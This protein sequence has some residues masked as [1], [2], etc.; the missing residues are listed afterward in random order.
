MP[1]FLVGD[2]LTDEMPKHLALLSRSHYV[3]TV[4]EEYPNGLSWLPSAKLATPLNAMLGP[5][6]DFELVKTIIPPGEPGEVRI[7]RRV[8]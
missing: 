8:K 4:T 5:T 1:A 7:Y 6:T 2:V 3:I